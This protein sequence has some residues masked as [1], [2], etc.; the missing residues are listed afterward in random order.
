MTVYRWQDARSCKQEV[1]SGG[2]RSNGFSTQQR[3]ESSVGLEST[4]TNKCTQGTARR[5]TLDLEEDVCSS[6]NQSFHLV[7]LKFK[8]ARINQTDNCFQGAVQTQVWPRDIE[9]LC[10]ALWSR[11]VLFREDK[12]WLHRA[13]SLKQVTFTFSI[14]LL[15]SKIC[16]L[17]SLSHC[18]LSL[19][20]VTVP[21]HPLTLAREYVHAKECVK[22]LKGGEEWELSVLSEHSLNLNHSSVTVTFRYI[23]DLRRNNILS[24][25]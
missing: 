11:S 12:I 6:H 19:K 17:L 9:H 25:S 21:F 14:P 1:S 13:L 7:A 20:E 3:Q 5:E 10:Q 16:L 8:I 24:P 15:S 18:A 23:H 4:E 22:K 2:M